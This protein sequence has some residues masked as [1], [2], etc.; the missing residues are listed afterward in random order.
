LILS[1]C[2]LPL[3]VAAQDRPLREAYPSDDFAVREAMVPMRDGVN[4]TR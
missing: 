1:F 3:G 4:S 2:V